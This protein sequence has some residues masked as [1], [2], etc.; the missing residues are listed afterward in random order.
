MILNRAKYIFKIKLLRV[1]D[2]YAKH[3]L[4]RTIA[5]YLKGLVY[6]T[7]KNVI[8]FEL[9]LDNLCFPFLKDANG[10]KV[11]EIKKSNFETIDYHGWEIS[12]EE[13]LNK[14]NEGCVLFAGMDDKTMVSQ[15]WS[16]LKKAFLFG[17]GLT[18]H[19]PDYTGYISRL[20][21]APNYRGMGV[22]TYT[23]GKALLYLKE[24]GY[25]KALVIIAEENQISQYVNC[26]FGFKPYQTVTLFRFLFIVKYYRVKDYFTEKKINFFAIKKDDQKIWRTFSKIHI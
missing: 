26:K 1:K 3:G 22:A 4:L 18:V 16:E 11:I 8:F 19:L 17:L 10:I 25:K 23:K 5:H 13:A 6:K 12:K 2:Y 24:L 15:Q 9:D 21:T 20:Y 7:S 14:L